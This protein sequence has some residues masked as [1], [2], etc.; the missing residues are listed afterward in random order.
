MQLVFLLIVVSFL[1]PGSQHPPMPK[2]MSHEEH[3][4][5]MEKAKQDALKHR[6]A[7]AMGFDQ[8]ATVHHFRLSAAGG[9][10]EVTAKAEN[11]DTLIG[12]VRTHLKVI[13]DE[14][15]RGI[16]DNPFKTHA[17]MPPGVDVM[18][19][20]AE[21]IAYTFEVVPKGA[22]VRIRTKDRR[23]LRA[24]HDFLKYQIKEHQTGDPL[25]VLR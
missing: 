7:E 2:G 9:S 20:R 17:E 3:V 6:G 18:Q 10:I 5:Q 14:F 1:G 25:V 24:I 16:F 23:A 12:E 8:D 19:K 13:A 11:A 22:T 4:K 21:T 15:S